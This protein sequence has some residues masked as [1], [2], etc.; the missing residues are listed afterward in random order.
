MEEIIENKLTE[1]GFRQVKLV[2]DVEVKEERMMCFVPIPA[3]EHAQIHCFQSSALSLFYGE[4]RW[5][6]HGDI[7]D[8]RAEVWAAGA[9]E[10]RRFAAWKL[11]PG[12]RMS[13]AIR[14]ALVYYTRYCSRFPQYA[15]A[16]TLPK[17]IESGIDVDDLILLQADW[18]PP[19][20]LLI[21]G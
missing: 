10:W 4:A 9:Y 14:S 13:E 20:C 19:G 1:D 5:P 3:R 7:V 8:I 12:E 11:M 15:F 2:S 21:G 17:T 18:V 6:A 16:R